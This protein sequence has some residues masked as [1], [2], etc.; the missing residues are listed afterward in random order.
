[1]Y[2]CFHEIRQESELIIDDDLKRVLY[3]EAQCH[4]P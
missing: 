1:M 2:T 3:F 4:G